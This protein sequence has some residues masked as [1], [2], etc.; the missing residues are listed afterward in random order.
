MP[1]GLLNEN[2]CG[3]SSGRPTPHEGQARAY[4]LSHIAS[5]TYT[6]E[7]FEVEMQKNVDT[8]VKA[9]KR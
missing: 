1:S 3:D 4:I 9:L 8:M 6:P 5:G 7:K 2:D